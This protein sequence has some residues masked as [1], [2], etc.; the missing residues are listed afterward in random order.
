MV[1]ESRSRI[2]SLGLCYGLIL[3][4]RSGRGRVESGF[5][6]VEGGRR[7]S[8]CVGVGVGVAV[9]GLMV[10]RR[11]SRLVVVFEGRVP[12]LLVVGMVFRDMVGGVCSHYVV[13]VVVVVEDKDAQNMMEAACSCTVMLV[14]AGIAVVLMNATGMHLVSDFL[15]VHGRLV[16]PDSSRALPFPVMS[17]Q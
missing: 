1:G 4:L 9:V 15:E 12:S 11:S 7:G 10:V 6:R 14:V 3:G 17:S 13:S 5:C 2:L 8:C 16:C